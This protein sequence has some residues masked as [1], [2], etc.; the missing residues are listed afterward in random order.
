MKRRRALL[1]SNPLRNSR[2]EADLQR[3]GGGGGSPLLLGFPNSFPMPEKRT[4]EAGPLVAL[5]P[6]SEVRVEAFPAI[7][8]LYIFTSLVYI[9]YSVSSLMLTRRA[10]S[11]S[12][13]A[14]CRG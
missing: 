13:P 11:G 7:A 6:V 10:G 5:G 14:A 4:A 9:F 12:L 2:S 1:A 3:S 8:I